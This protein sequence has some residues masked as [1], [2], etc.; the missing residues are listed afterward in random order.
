[1]ASYLKNTLITIPTHNYN[2]KT[3]EV[4]HLNYTFFKFLIFSRL[5]VLLL[6]QLTILILYVGSFSCNIKVYHPTGACISI[7]FQELIMFKKTCN[8][9]NGIHSIQLR[10][11]GL[12]FFVIFYSLQVLGQ[13]QNALLIGDVRNCPSIYMTPE[14]ASYF[15]RTSQPV[16]SSNKNDALRG[17]R[18]LIKL[19]DLGA[20]AIT[21]VGT[22]IEQF[23]RAVH[24]TEIK[25]VRYSGEGTFEDWMSTYV[26]NEKNKFM[27][28]SPFIDY[29]NISLCE[30]YIDAVPQSSII[31]QQPENG[32]VIKSATVN[33]T[34]TF[35]VYFGTCALS[36]ITGMTIGNN[37]NDW[38]I[39]WTQSG[40]NAIES[41]YGTVSGS[42]KAIASGQTFNDLIVKAKYRMSLT[43]GDEFI[44]FVE[45]KDDTSVIFETV[46]G[47]P[48]IFAKKLIDRCDL[49]DLPKSLQKQP[50]SPV[51]KNTIITESSE[52]QFESLL[53]GTETNHLL[54]VKINSGAL[55]KGKLET[56]DQNGLKLNID[57]SSI[58]ISK[59]VIHTIAILKQREVKPQTAPV[60][61][62]P[63]DTIIV[64]STI[65]DDW[66]RANPDIVHQGT[67]VNENNNGFTLKLTD[68]NTIQI[69]QTDIVRVIK[70]TNVAAEND[71]VKRYAKPLIC[72]PGMVM[73]DFPPGSSNKPFFKT[74]ID[75]YEYP[76]REGSL[77][78]G[79]LSFADAKMLCEQQGKRLCT[80]EEW[81]WSC[82][83]FDNL[84]YPYGKT[85]EEN[86]CN[87]AS[88]VEISGARI[89]CASKF[90]IYDM[91]G[92][93]FEWVTTADGQ[94]AMMGGPASK[95]QTV[96]PGTGGSAKPMSG[97]R[98]CKSN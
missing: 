3:L 40:G 44:G 34:I 56:I 70:H 91:T 80:A 42:Q 77:P 76:N 28:S 69:R 17:Y 68:G 66:G 67:I 16:F 25:A 24:V 6:S 12:L 58:P 92:N 97:V 79:N 54:E 90:G 72:P 95:C 19:G 81:Q 36:R 71:P 48:Y 98:C 45:S 61:A 65:V 27:L 63:L 35:T 86:R 43:T 85:L 38:R 94:P 5:I 14:A 41:R 96:S 26:M 59:E 78:Q 23:P 10:F 62:G 93:I 4:K 21:S 31:E 15:Q 51:T 7:S 73:V 82:G 22:I 11:S 2:V 1:M 55:F 75:K 30:Q 49:L 52:V 89:N 88:S 20:G 74:C 13:D 64:K 47:K 33:L 8:P 83:G 18:A 57:G 9:K 32:N 60:P 84:S 37:Q 46:D 39:W 87:T 29:N 50:A 53:S